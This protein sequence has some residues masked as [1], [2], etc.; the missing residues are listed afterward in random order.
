MF[1]VFQHMAMKC[2]ATLAVLLMGMISVAAVA[3]P[4]NPDKVANTNDFSDIRRQVETL[5]GKKF[6]TEVPVY[7]ISK[8]ELRAISDHEIEKDYP[9][10]KLRHY[11]EMLAWLDMV[12][13]HTDLKTAYGDLF[14]ET[15]AGLYN[16]ET[17]EMCIPA[18]AVGATN[19]P[20]KATE[21][22]LEAVTP[23]M[24]T[25][26][27]AHEF[28]HALED[29]YWLM[30][31]PR[32][33][34]TTISTDRG[35][36]HS[37]VLEGSATREMMEAV[38]AQF[39]GKSALAYFLFWNAIHS[40]LGEFSL[41]CVLS[42]V[43]K[44][45]D[46]VVGGVPD[47]LGRSE[48]MPYAFGYSFC[49]EIMRQWGLDGLDYIYEHP[50]VSSAQVMHPEKAWEWRDL[51]VQI[52]LPETPAGGWKQTSLD[53]VGE[54]GMAALF[55]TQ[56]KNLNRG[57][58]VARGWDGD[59][60]A[61][62]EDANGHKLFVWAS[63]WDSAEAAER[64]AG[65]CVRER[66]LAH[67]AV[68]TAAGNRTDWH[69]QDGRTGF[70]RRDGKRVIL[71]ET[72]DRETLK[73]A[74]ACASEI[75]FVEPP[76]DAARA[77]INSPMRRFNPFWS[78]Q[79]DGDYTITKSALGLLSRHDRNSVGA[80]DSFLCGMLGETRRTTSLNKWELGC[81]LVARHESE[82]RRGMTKT[83]WLPWGVLA[84]FSSAKVP[85]APEKTI[86]RASVLW[87]LAGSATTEESGRRSFHLLPFGL[88]LRDT[89]AP[90]LSSF[91]IV[92]T[93]VSHKESADKTH[94]T[95]RFRLLGISLWTT[96]K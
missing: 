23:E 31:D 66:E 6:K 83:T 24:D 50:V 84:S 20:K 21:K 76:E 88:L 85:Q 32:D 49:T 11:E 2:R 54:A 59:H 22:K 5:R 41:N 3:E 53:S 16:S 92:G 14:V 1:N 12:P 39:G 15:V 28:T 37:F 62:Y 68:S 19:A 44:G 40:D 91:H 74:E 18:Y 70:I 67:R 77:A 75:T 33:K 55:G 43:W 25:I 4:S 63:S 93:G 8:K 96:R 46:A 56:F 29:Q 36:A 78:W 51:P 10:E 13:R 72:D 30:D 9:G 90:G 79:K 71:L 47:A 87:G 26:V 58:Q 7:D 82:A 45:G 69:S 81:G 94:A 57:L 42:D 60:V 38:P 73:A 27:M 48:A 65:A 95:T 35:T 89:K 86:K 64:Y 34:D 17:K 80:A 52:N 61:L